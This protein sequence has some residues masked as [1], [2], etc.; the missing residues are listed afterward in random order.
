MVAE[1]S[2]RL[3]EL[4]EDRI[5]SIRLVRSDK[6][7]WP[8]PGFSVILVHAAQRIELVG[9]TVEE[10]ELRLEVHVVA[11][12]GACNLLPRDSVGP[13]VRQICSAERQTI[14]DPALLTSR[15]VGIDAELIDSI[16]ARQFGSDGALPIIGVWPVA[17]F[18]VSVA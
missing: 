6:P 12:D 4:P 2:H 14:P 9:A 10:R 8:R 11:A 16:R 18:T 15:L 7:G 17:C 1:L 3:S 13:F 5:G